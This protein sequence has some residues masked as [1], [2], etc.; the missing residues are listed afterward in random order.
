M[1]TPIPPVIAK[2]APDGKLTPR[3]VRR[4]MIDMVMRKGKPGTGSGHDFMRRRTADIAW[5]DLREV[6]ANVKWA[7]AGAVATRAYMP[8]RMTQA[9]DVLVHPSDGDSVIKLLEGKGYSVV[10]PLR[11]ETGYSMLS[12]DGVR[13]NILHGN[14]VWLEEALMD[15]G[16]DPIGYPVLKLPYLV[17]M[18]MQ[19]Q[20]IWNMGDLGT[21]LGWASDA[22]L[23]EVRKVVA[24]YAPEDSDDLESLIFIGKRE[25]ELPPD[26]S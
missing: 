22:D 3:Q 5:P 23:E 2:I 12:P 13:V 18:K 11:I 16:Q 8:E 21:M 1:T 17:L 15:V 4:L 14:Y 24:E 20:R 9:M 6:L 26:A 25:R 10:S 7:I 19:S